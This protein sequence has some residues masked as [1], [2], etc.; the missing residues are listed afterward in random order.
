MPLET[1]TTLL[2][3]TLN[4]VLVHHSGPDQDLRGDSLPTKS[5]VA[6]SSRHTFDTKEAEHVRAG[7]ANRVDTGLLADTAQIS[8]SSISGVSVL[9][10]RL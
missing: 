6:V 2:D 7:K 4:L 3:A 9:P 10:R 8:T 1:L 5:T